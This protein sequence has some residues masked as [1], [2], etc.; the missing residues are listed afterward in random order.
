MEFD[1]QIVVTA[2]NLAIGQELFSVAL[3]PAVPT[4]LRLVPLAGNERLPT[5]EWNPSSAATAYDV[6]IN[7][8]SGRRIFLETTDVN[9]FTVPSQ[10]D[11]GSYTIWFDRRMTKASRD[12]ALR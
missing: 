2:S 1:G 4:E 11:A 12:G 7:D 5:F 3:P 8:A 9:G 6:W 10:L